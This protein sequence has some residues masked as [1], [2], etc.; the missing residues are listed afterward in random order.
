MGGVT[1]VRID[2]G[3]D[4][5][6]LGELDQKLWTALSCPVN[7]LEFDREFL[8]YIDS[9]HDGRIRVKEVV[10]AS[11]WICSVLKDRDLLL[12]SS[13]TLPLS[14]FDTN[15]VEGQRLEKSARRV[16]ESIGKSSKESISMEDTADSK[17][18]FSKTRFNGDGIV[19]PLSAGDDDK[20]KDAIESALKCFPA[21]LDRSGQDGVDAATVEAFYAALLSYNAWIDAKGDEC[22]PFGADSEKVFAS[23]EALKGLVDGYFT[24]CEYFAY[25]PECEQAKESA[26]SLSHPNSDILLHLDRINPKWAAQVEE[27]RELAIGSEVK[28]LTK[29]DWNALKAK[30][31]PLQAWLSA[32]A[33]EQVEALGPEKVAQLH[34]ENRKTEVLSLIEKDLSLKEE[35]D[36]IDDVHNLLLVYRHLYEFLNNFVRFG[37]FYDRDQKSVFDAGE[38]YIDQR[39]L[40]LCIRVNDMGKQ[41][42]MAPQSG[43]YILYC[44]CIS[45]KTGKTATIAA[46]LTD[47]SSENLSTGMNAVFYDRNGLDYDATVTK[48]IDNPTSIRQ[49]FFHPYRKLSKAIND[50]I[51]KQ[52]AEKE[53][54][55]TS[56]LTELANST[57]PAGAVPK[58]AFDPTTMLALT[59]G[60]GVGAGVILNAVSALVKPWYTL[61]LVIAGLCLV[62]S[63]P[64]MFL[65]WLKL[66]KRNLGPIL[67]ANGWAI[68]SA[69]LVNSL[70]GATLTSLA[71]YPKILTAGD[72]FAIKKKSPLPYIIAIFLIAGVVLCVLSNM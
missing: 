69:V 3:E 45:K 24:Q 18:I 61:L 8:E 46:L 17:A 9:D 43:M 48:I 34:A 30:F 59:A 35:A 19:T 54:K 6:H 47:G 41:T 21:S 11:D 5:A 66:R 42:M 72:P 49:A 27:L 64:S 53:N 23:I 57:A 44:D 56:G 31:A 7:G 13:D 15:S 70:F 39:C 60:V 14:A 25:D 63:G 67:N 29:A 68:N 12:D 26:D 28:V 36:S 2:S 1:R 51:N 10:K 20:S 40:K 71:K 58:K 16:L 38:L 33:G 52:A 50:R 37:A 65:A 22:S 4:I 55:V 62:I 32:K